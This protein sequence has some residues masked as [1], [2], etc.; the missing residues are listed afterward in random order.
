MKEQRI[1]QIIDFTFEFRR[2]FSQFIEKKTGLT[3]AQW[4]VMK[5]IKAN[6]GI[7][8]A[9]EVAD[10]LNSDRV[11]TS[12]IVNRLEKKNFINKIIDV[13]DKRKKLLNITEYAHTFCKNVMCL[14][15]QYINQLLANTNSTEAED[16][17]RIMDLMKENIEDNKTEV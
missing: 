1:K 7:I 13:K 8:T 2:G 17:F 4:R 3:F 6:E 16:F 14:E 5:V 9:K 10:I 12:D 11:T 15:E